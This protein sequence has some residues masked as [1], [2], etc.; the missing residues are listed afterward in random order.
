MGFL[1]MNDNL[2]I[3]NMLPMIL[4]FTTDEVEFYVKF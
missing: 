2:G 3:M 4:S 1:V